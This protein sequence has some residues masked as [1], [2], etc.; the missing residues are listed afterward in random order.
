METNNNIGYKPWESIPS[1][2]E[3]KAR[4]QHRHYKRPQLLGKVKNAEQKSGT[5]TPLTV[6]GKE[7]EIINISELMAKRQ[8]GEVSTDR[9]NKVLDDYLL[10]EKCSKLKSKTFLEN[11]AK[12]KLPSKYIMDNDKYIEK[13]SFDKYCAGFYRPKDKFYEPQAKG[14]MTRAMDRIGELAEI[15]AQLTDKSKYIAEKL[16]EIR[17]AAPDLF[18]GAKDILK[19][20]KK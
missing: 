11:S 2:K 13:I 12:T 3:M 10:S 16:G 20:F 6:N 19:T 5:S 7:V 14:P 18:K 8:R 17:E 1:K 15:K 9:E 4:R